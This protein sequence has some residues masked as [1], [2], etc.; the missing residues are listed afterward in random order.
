MAYK[1]LKDISLYT[2]LLLMSETS[3]D[4]VTDD[5][6]K[7]QSEGKILNMIDKIIIYNY[8]KDID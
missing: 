7:P 5:L 6:E 2:G 4:P 3:F 1:L 8:I